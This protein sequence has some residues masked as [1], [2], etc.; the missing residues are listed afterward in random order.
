MAGPDLDDWLAEPQVRTRHRVGSTA[1]P[2]ELWRAAAT[3]LIRDAP[4]FGRAVRWRIPGTP[5]ERSFRDLLR[6]YPFAILAEDRHCSIS[7]LCGRIW[8]MQRDYPH[9]GGADEFREWSEPG[10][11]RVAIAHWVEDAPAGSALF[12][13]ARIEPVDGRASARLR[14]LWALVGGFD[15]FVG[16]EPLATAVRRAE[17]PGVR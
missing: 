12:S 10:T 4:L 5:A 6:R 14:V 15:R 8:S 13:E 3:V 17:H 1:S 16:R 2:D 7:G 9:I 11:V